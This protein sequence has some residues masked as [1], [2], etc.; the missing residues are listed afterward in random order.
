MNT[1]RPTRREQIGSMRIR[2]R[3]QRQIE[4]RL[5]AIALILS[6]WVTSAWTLMVTTGIAHRDWWHLMPPMG[7]GAAFALTAI[8]LA[9][10][11][12]ATLTHEILAR[13]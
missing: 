1:P 12:V 7:A 8:P 9:V 13:S 2:S 10:V 5:L 4:D 11:I 6:A 3:R